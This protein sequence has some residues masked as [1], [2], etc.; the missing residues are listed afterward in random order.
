MPYFAIKFGTRSTTTVQDRLVDEDL[1]MCTR[2]IIIVIRWQSG[3]GLFSAGNGSDCA[4]AL[5]IPIIHCFYIIYEPRIILYPTPGQGL[6]STK[7]RVEVVF[8]VR[9]CSVCV[10]IFYACA[11]ELN[12]IAYIILLIYTKI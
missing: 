9:L 6:I 1:L 5:L 8:V 4:C 3:Y 11:R 7:T 12:P 10:F 2:H